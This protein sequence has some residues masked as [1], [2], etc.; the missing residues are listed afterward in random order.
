MTT[1]TE[2]VDGTKD[3]ILI[4]GAGNTIMA[5]EGIGPRCLEEL[6]R[7]FEFPANVTLLDVGTTGLGIIDDLREVDRVII[8]DAAQDTGHP[9]GT[10]L[11]LTPQELAANQVMHSAHDVRMVDVFTAASMMGI[12]FKSVVII[13]VQVESLAAFVLEL[14]ESVAAAIPIACAA[15]LDQLQLMGINPAL[16]E[17]EAMPEAMV[18]ALENFG[19]QPEDELDEPETG[20]SN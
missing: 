9:A 11:L 5:D 6:I 20:D 17:G 7:L 19:P 3:Q 18:D 16:R 4:M 8:L 2:K 15:A 13:A 12:D 10:V 14:S 1:F